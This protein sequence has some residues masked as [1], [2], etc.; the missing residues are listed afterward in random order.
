MKCKTTKRLEAS[1]HSEEK[2]LIKNTMPAQSDYKYNLFN[3]LDEPINT[4]CS[5]G[6]CHKND[7]IAPKI[8]KRW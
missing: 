6:L 5:T 4:K 8:K 3:M 2:M 1:D 7:I